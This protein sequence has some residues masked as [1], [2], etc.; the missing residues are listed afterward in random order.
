M[1][2]FETLEIARLVNLKEVV[3]LGFYKPEIAYARVWNPRNCPG[4]GN[5]REIVD[6][7]QTSQLFW[8]KI[9][10]N[11]KIQTKTSKT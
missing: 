7:I 1:L 10:Q 5:S 9:K 2:G 6:L 11:K 3:G 8:I 4:Y